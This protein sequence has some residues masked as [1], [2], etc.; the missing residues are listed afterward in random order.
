MESCEID[1]FVCKRS[2]SIKRWFAISPASVLKSRNTFESSESLSAW[3]IIY[4]AFANSLEKYAV[5][6]WLVAIMSAFQGNVA[7]RNWALTGPHRKEPYFTQKACTKTRNTETKPPKPPKLPK[8]N[9]RNHRNSYKNLNKTIEP[10]SV[11]PPLL[12]SGRIVMNKNFSNC[13]FCCLGLCTVYEVF[14][15][16][17]ASN[18]QESV[19]L[20]WPDMPFV[21]AVYS[22]ENA[23]HCVI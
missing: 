16:S 21:A 15:T 23:L 7:C 12:N 6:R 20:P 14:F 18:F 5:R 4:V 1:F 9:D 11:T 22:W 2:E 8:R 3:V 17:N 19:S 13:F 10:A